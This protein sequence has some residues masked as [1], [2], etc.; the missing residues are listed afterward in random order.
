VAAERRGVISGL[1]SLSRNLGLIT[2]TSVMG[3]LFAH[4]VGGATLAEASPQA[5]A[6]GTKASFI[7]AACLMALA[8]AIRVTARRRGGAR[9]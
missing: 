3:A 8:V 2:G 5:V 7:A 9:P 6:A 4:V 1:L